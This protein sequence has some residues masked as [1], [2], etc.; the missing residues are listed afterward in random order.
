MTHMQVGSAG[1]GTV[2]ANW[3]ISLCFVVSQLSLANQKTGDSK[4][5]N[6]TA[7]VPLHHM[8]ASVNALN[9]RTVSSYRPL[10]AVVNVRTV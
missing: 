6:Q 5:S 10:D 1:S 2:I 7:R 4:Q 3:L 8:Q 9:G